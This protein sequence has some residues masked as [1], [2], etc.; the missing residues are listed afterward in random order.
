MAIEI[1]VKNRIVQEIMD[2][3]RELRTQ[4]LVQGVDFDFAYKPP[5][6][7]NFSHDPVQE[8]HTV[9]TFYTEKYSTLFAIKY[10]S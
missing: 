9:F 5:V 7:D 1:I 6:W 10:G 2:I 3:V 4:G 8:K